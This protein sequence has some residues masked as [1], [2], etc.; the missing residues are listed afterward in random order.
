MKWSE[1]AEQP[2]PIARGLAVVGDRWTLLVLRDCFLGVRRFDEFQARIGMPR[3]VLSERLGALVAE[4]VL[5]KRGPEYRLTAK[6][7]DLYPVLMALAGWSNRHRVDERGPPLIYRH[8]ACGHEATPVLACPDCG[9]PVT[10]E[11]MEV[12]PGNGF[13][14]PRAARLRDAG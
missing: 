2:C 12:R 8:K 4:A 14:D 5:E 7:R 11:A 10:A 6:G 1:L 13:P 9:E 3:A